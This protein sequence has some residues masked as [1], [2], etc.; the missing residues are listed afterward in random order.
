MG[1]TLQSMEKT[2]PF[3]D[4]MLD[5][6]FDEEGAL[7][8]SI[9]AVA[10]PRPGF[11]PQSLATAIITCSLYKDPTGGHAEFLIRNMLRKEMSTFSNT[12]SPTAVGRLL[13][14]FGAAMYAAFARVLGSELLNELIPPLLE[15][16]RKGKLGK[17]DKKGCAGLVTFIEGIPLALHRMPASM[18]KLASF[19]TR[20]LMDPGPALLLVKFLSQALDNHAKYLSKPI[21][22]PKEKDKFQKRLTAVK[23]FFLRV[24]TTE[25][26]VKVETK[27]FADANPILKE[28]HASWVSAYDNWASKDP[29]AAPAA[30]TI[31]YT[32][33]DARAAIKIWMEFVDG[34]SSFELLLSKPIKATLA[35]PLGDLFFGWALPVGTRASTIVASASK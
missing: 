32:W 29:S 22:D 2:H 4:E 26:L 17:L 31:I 14:G 6:L 23:L 33:E 10:S 9:A 27:H 5:V 13:N 19:L 3:A 8:D 25:P 24:A 30:P 35:F 16:V 1:E 11:D 18:W 12:S 20:Q 21:T 7:I 15:N 34:D 28:A